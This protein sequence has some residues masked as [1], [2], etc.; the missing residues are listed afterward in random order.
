[1][2]IFLNIKYL[3]KKKKKKKKKK[4]VLSNF[5]ILLNLKYYK[6]KKKKK[7]KKKLINPLNKNIIH[8]FIVFIFHLRFIFF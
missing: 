1:M 7:K 3:K 5:Y 4:L 6:F 2:I 8:H